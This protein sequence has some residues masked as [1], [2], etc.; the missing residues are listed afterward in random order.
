MIQKVKK[1]IYVYIFSFFNLIFNQFYCDNYE[2]KFF[3]DNL[4]GASYSICQS[5]HNKFVEQFDS[6]QFFGDS[7][8][9][10]AIIEE[11]YINGK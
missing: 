3:R 1:N 7:V 9:L 10:L 4:S 8:S 2:L 6:S 11:C 5:K